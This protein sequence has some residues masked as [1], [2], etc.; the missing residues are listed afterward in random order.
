V[1]FRGW[2]LH[3]HEDGPPPVDLDTEDSFA[4]QSQAQADFAA[5][6]F[7]NESVN[8]DPEH[9]S[10]YTFFVPKRYV[11][12]SPVGF[13]SSWI[14]QFASPNAVHSGNEAIAII[15]SIGQQLGIDLRMS[16]KHQGVFPWDPSGR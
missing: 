2:H 5:A 9:V 4:G 10:G 15:D 7:V 11:L 14:V 3:Y 1:Y 6:A 13:V 8:N 16:P 12:T